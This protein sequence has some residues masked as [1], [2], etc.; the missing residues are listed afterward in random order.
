MDVTRR[1]E[2]AGLAALDLTE[3]GKLDVMIN[4]AG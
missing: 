1:E 3:F 2:V 4:N